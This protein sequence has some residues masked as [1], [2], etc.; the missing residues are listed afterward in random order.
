MLNRL[1][2]LI[3]AIASLF[4]CDYYAFKET[5]TLILKEAIIIDRE[6]HWCVIEKRKYINGITYVVKSMNSKRL[7]TFS[8]DKVIF[9]G[10]ACTPSLEEEPTGN[11][12]VRVIR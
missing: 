8:S 4:G 12:P 11:P 5:P 3:A 7:E 9:T 2:L 6:S 10:R 1:L